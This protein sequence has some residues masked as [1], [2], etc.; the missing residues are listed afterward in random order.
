MIMTAMYFRLL[1]SITILFVLRDWYRIE[2]LK[3]PIDH[4]RGFLLRAFT[5]L[6]IA[7]VLQD[8]EMVENLI[9]TPIIEGYI[10]QYGLNLARR[11]PLV[12]LNPRSDKFDYWMMKIFRY[13]KW[14]FVFMTTL[15]I[16]AMVWKLI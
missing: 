9:C 14:V 2:I 4:K 10:F 12:Y 8:H 3:K 15:F 16:G 5:C 11:K 6:A 7:L 1:I 13:A